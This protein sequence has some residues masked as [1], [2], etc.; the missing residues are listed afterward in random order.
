MMDRVG[1]RIRCVEMAVEFASGRAI[2]RVNHLAA[3]EIFFEWASEDMIYCD[4]RA[5]CIA[6]AAKECK[7]RGIRHATEVIKNAIKLDE[8]INQE[9]LQPEPKKKMVRRPRGAKRKTS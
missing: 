1:L 3:A 4:L 2:A 8:F 9:P 5:R 6:Q 7:G